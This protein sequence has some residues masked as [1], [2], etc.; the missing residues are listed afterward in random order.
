MEVYLF[1]QDSWTV[2][3]LDYSAERMSYISTTWATRNNIQ[4]TNWQVWLS[5]S[6]PRDETTYRTRFIES[7]NLT[8]DFTLGTKSMDPDFNNVKSDRTSL[9][10]GK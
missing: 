10:T 5:W 6:L 4:F 9:P 3:G 8:S 1:E 2:A 7:H